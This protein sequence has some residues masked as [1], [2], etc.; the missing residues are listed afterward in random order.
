MATSPTL[1]ETTLTVAE[2]TADILAAADMAIPEEMPHRIASAV[3]SAATFPDLIAAVPDPM[4]AT[5]RPGTTADIPRILR[6]WRQYCLE[7][8]ISPSS[9]TL[10]FEHWHYHSNNASVTHLF[11]SYKDFLAAQ[12]A[13]MSNRLAQRQQARE[14]ERTR[15]RRLR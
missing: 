11:P 10:K 8:D 9:P 12:D 14:R 5:H 2:S 6:E 1:A 15:E 4:A 13:W 3:T 7:R